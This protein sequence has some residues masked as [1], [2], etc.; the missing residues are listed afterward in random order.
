MRDT[1]A[2]LVLGVSALALSSGAADAQIAP[3]GESSPQTQPVG[4]TEAPSGN[5]DAVDAPQQPADEGEIVVTGIRQSLERSIQVKRNAVQILDSISAE[6][7]G[8]LP[9]QNIAE[10]LQR[11]SGVQV[12]RGIGDAS[13][14]S[15][16]GLRQVNVLLN[17]RPITDSQ[18]RGGTG[19]D[20]LNSGSYGVF[21]VLPSE[22]VAR[23]DVLKLPSASDIEGGIGGTVNIVTRRP[24]DPGRSIIAGSVQGYYNEMRGDADF[25]VSGLFTQKFADDRI[26]ILVN[27]VYSDRDIREDSFN[28]FAGYLPLGAGFNTPANPTGADPNGDGVPGYYLADLRYQRLNDKRRRVAVNGAL[29]WQ[30]SPET[31]FY[32]EALYTK[33]TSDRDRSWLAVPL[34][35]DRSAYDNV[36]F[37][38]T[39]TIIAGTIRAQVQNNREVAQIDTALLST[40]FGGSY[41]DD[42]A[43]VSGEFAF[44]RARSDLSQTFVRLRS[45]VPVA[46][47][48]DFRDRDVPTLAL[49][50]TFDPT[51]INQL[52]FSNVF[53]NFGP[54]ISRE[55]AGRFDVALNL[56]SNFGYSLETGMRW[57]RLEVDNEFNRFE[58]GLS[59]AIAASTLPASSELYSAEDFF[60][61]RQGAFP[62]AIRVGVPFANG[63][64]LACRNFLPDCQPT[65]T[66]NESYTTDEDLLAAYV[67]FAFDTEVGGMKLGGNIGVRYTTTDQDSRGNLIIP[68][69]NQPYQVK[70]GYSD[71][72]P[73]AIVRLNVTDDLIVRFGAAKVMTRP[74]SSDLRAALAVVPAD[75]TGSGGNPRLEPFR[76]NQVDLSVEYYYGAGALLSAGLFYKDIKSFLVTQAQ[77]ELVP[78]YPNPFSLLRTING[79]GGKVQGI[80]TLAQVPFTFLPGFLD[81]FGV[82]ASYTFID[83]TSDQ[84]NIRDGVALPIPGLSKHNVNVIGYYDKGPLGVRVAYNWR[85]RYLDGIGIGGS[86][87]FFDSYQDLSATL[88]FDI[89][90]NIGLDIEGANLL[91][92]A[93]RRFGGVEDATASYAIFGRTY[94]ATVRFKF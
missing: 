22:L 78:G 8:K 92:S 37:T 76:A 73:S 35:G 39:D 60:S 4:Q 93:L 7:I 91:N 48:F 46:A 12:R 72:L 84:V 79:T 49:P 67:K 2:R 90:K 13:S 25:K 62:I 53:D 57:S 3:P 40:A 75:L 28:S 6:D 23:L 11:V 50:T 33:Q 45:R 89:T 18:G 38:P 54:T 64:A 44:S 27:A 1:F 58:R 56:G 69:G 30:P 59:P 5:P 20:T 86:G 31:D 26:G 71:W 85:N 55:Y 70:R 52:E 82:S 51:N 17:G 19:P 83:S 41:K 94:S 29:Q 15:I 87:T 16:R 74:N 32:A 66:P 47:S 77:R 42:R 24:L 34:S 88:R 36:V 63:V 80:E 14:I 81:G 21:A 10:S 61:G 65:V 68:T 9:D 43:R